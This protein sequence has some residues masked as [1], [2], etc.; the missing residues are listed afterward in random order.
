MAAGGSY[1]P[2]GG[3]ALVRQLNVLRQRGRGPIVTAV[4]ARV[5]P[6]EASLEFEN[7][8]GQ[9]AVRTSFCLG[10]PGD[11]KTGAVGDIPPGGFASVPISP[12]VAKEPVLCIWTCLDA[13]R[14]LTIWSYEGRRRRLG[15]GRS[16]S[17][18]DSFR[19]MYPLGDERP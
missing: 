11:L 4:L 12:E 5:S 8:G 6:G 16:E 15:A 13:R 10:G 1:S 18:S 9:T 7:E 3:R 2:F 19:R 14:R 17:L